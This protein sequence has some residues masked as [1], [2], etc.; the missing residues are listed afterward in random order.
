MDALMRNADEEA[1][2]LIEKL[3]DNLNMVNRAPER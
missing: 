3:G 2:K 1:T